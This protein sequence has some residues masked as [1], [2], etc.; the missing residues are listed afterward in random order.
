[1]EIKARSQMP[2]PHWDTAR[3][4]A[5]IS[6]A[7]Q[8]EEERYKRDKF[9]N[10]QRLRGMRRVRQRGLQLLNAQSRQPGSEFR[11]E[12][13]DL[14]K[15]RT[16]PPRPPTRTATS[17]FANIMK[18]QVRFRRL[19][20]W[21][22]FSTDSTGR[23]MAG[24]E[25]G[26]V[27]FDAAA[28]YEA[29]S[30][31]RE[32]CLIK[33]YLNADPP[34]HP[35]R[36]LEQTNEWTLSLSWHASAR[37]QVVH[38]ATRPKQLDFHSVDPSTKEWRDRIRKLPRVMMIDQLWMWI[39]DEQT[40]ITCFPEYGDLSHHNHLPGI[41]SRMRDVILKSGKGGIRTVYDLAVIILGEV[42]TSKANMSGIK[43]RLP[44]LLVTRSKIPVEIDKLTMTPAA[45]WYASGHA[46]LQASDS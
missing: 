39:L 6:D 38:R 13:R 24:T 1:V 37:D 4:Q 41:H 26:Q 22:V 17:A 11:L 46:A 45:G 29:M 3:H 12:N 19:P 43:A 20:L 33:K 21:S 44:S 23:V 10:E 42:Q 9:M 35:R 5:K 7:V 31:H 40:I 30:T 36:T 18:R 16:I 15:S 14:E 34:L 8:K 27:F 32:K 2:Y 28:L 25:L